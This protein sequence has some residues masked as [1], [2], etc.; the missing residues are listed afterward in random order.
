M[1]R[2]LVSDQGG[3]NQLTRLGYVFVSYTY[4]VSFWSCVHDCCTTT[5]RIAQDRYD[6]GTVLFDC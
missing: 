3:D 2:W 5:I 4:R 6:Q 1:V